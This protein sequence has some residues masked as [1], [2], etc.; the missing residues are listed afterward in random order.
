MMLNTTLGRKIWQTTRVNI[1]QV[2]ITRQYTPGIY[3]NQIHPWYNQEHTDLALWKGVLEPS[4]E[5]TYAMYPYLG[6]QC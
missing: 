3:M 2:H 6:S 1:T 4:P 5:G